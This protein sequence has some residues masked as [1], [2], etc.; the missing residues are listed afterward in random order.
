MFEKFTDRSRT[1]MNLASAEAARR[2]DDSIDTV[3]VLVGMLREGKES[4]AWHVL[5]FHCSVPVDVDLVLAARQAVCDLPDVA[6]EELISQSLLEAKWLDHRYV[7]T[8]HLLLAVCALVRSRAA[9]LL[10]DSG[11]GPVQVCSHILDIVGRARDDEL[12][13]WLVDHPDA[14]QSR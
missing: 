11:N 7:G 6:F 8:E 14:A 4:V 10:A 5:S 12:E 13:R 1:V 2:G 9:R 3:D